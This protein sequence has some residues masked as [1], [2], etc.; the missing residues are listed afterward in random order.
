MGGAPRGRG[1]NPPVLK[2]FGQH[3]LSDPSILAAI[4][5]ALAPTRGDTVVEIGPGR[6]SLTSILASRTDRLIAIEIDRALAAQ[7]RNTYAGKPN[8]VIVEGDVLD[9]DIP[10]L[11]G[12]DY[13]LIGN[14]PYYITTPIIF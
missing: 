14:V 7:L 1:G 12:S 4:V 6:G 2:K 9:I 3:F 10:G 8:V 11:A 5:D 13:L